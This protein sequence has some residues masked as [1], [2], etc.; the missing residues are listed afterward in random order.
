MKP[1][2]DAGDSLAELRKRAEQSVQKRTTDIFDISAFSHGQA[3]RLIHDLQVHQVELEM[4]NEE[5]RRA[6]E[7]LEE[8]RDNYAELYDFSPVSY[9]TLDDRGLI[10]QVN[11]TGAKLLELERAFLIGSPFISF[12]GGE[13]RDAFQFHFKSVFESQTTQTCEIEL[14]RKDGGTFNARLE[15]SMARDGAV[16][17]LRCQTVVS[18]ISDLKRAEDA[19]RT[20]R[21]N[22]VN[23]LDAMSDGVYIVNQ[24]YDIQYV[25]NAIRSDFGPWQG[26]KC[27]EYFHGRD[28][29]CPWCKNREVF[30][31]KKVRWEWSSSKTGKTY[32]LI[33]TLLRN[34]DG[35]SAKLEIFRDITDRKQAEDALRESEAKY[36]LLI[37][38][39][40][41]GIWAI[42]AEGRTTFVNPRMAEI[43]GYSSE[44]MLGCSI[45]TFMDEDAKALAREYMERRRQGITEQ[46][47]FEF[48]RKDGT[49]VYTALSTSA[50]TDDE[51]KFAGAL[52]CVSD[53][54]ERKIA[55]AALQAAHDQLEKRVEERT[56]AL[57]T[58]NEKLYREV[59]ERK[60]AE[61]EIKQLTEELEERV[62]ERTAELETANRELESFSYSVS[63]D[64]RAPL[65]SI[66][67]FSEI[68]ARRHRADL[69]EEGRHYVDNIIE[70]SHHMDRLIED[71][72]AYSRL[73]RQ[74]HRRQQVALRSVF[75]QVLE[76]F[77]DR[78]TQSN[79][80][81]IVPKKLPTVFGDRTLL[82]QIF[83]NL[84]NNALT[85]RRPKVS[86]KVTIS[87]EREGDHVV[88]RVADNGIGIPLECHGKIFN[89]F[90]RLHSQ[91][92]FP[93][94]G[95][96]L[97]I[98]KKSVESL[99]GRVWLE[100]T[101]GRGTTFYVNIPVKSRKR[102]QNA[103]HE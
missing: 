90:Q 3:Q 45:F 17:A 49:T 75:T 14:T 30:A 9:F 85:Y 19:L 97:A 84:I 36:R 88:V 64:L 6:Q 18:D 21:D 35:R 24:Q 96:G 27:Y 22:L 29:A 40:Q 95:I 10:Q 48:L 46:H 68:V 98:V 15:S 20:E 91:D 103:V 33:D 93:G 8:S 44:D 50:I 60:W 100:S 92:E 28:D 82:F 71:L 102:K 52:A 62:Q 61:E 79:A 31:G 66:T 76:D 2:N 39:A 5:L 1:H 23:V 77:S 78:M 63:H 11:L 58:A 34:P 55:E 69:N 43:L 12:V 74:A 16:D 47:D 42:D 37:E 25:N 94:T 67:G 4:Q 57:V 7:E 70:A 59:I 73:G 87:Y 81:I 53:I 65:R 54:S 101:V 41:E 26:H 99:R 38:S 89:L 32:D 83:A 56:R 51:G 80:E 13:S 86:P 72:L